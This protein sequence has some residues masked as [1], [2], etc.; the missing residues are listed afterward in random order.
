M[1]MLRREPIPVPLPSPVTTATAT[2]LAASMVT[3]GPIRWLLAA[4]AGFV[5]GQAI[6]RNASQHVRNEPMLRDK[7]AD[8]ASQDSFP[9][10]DAPSFTS[11]L[12]RFPQ[13]AVKK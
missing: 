8:T 4:A 9:A 13:A 1:N 10:S 6:R 2:L 5:A 11:G 7:L 12:R 3:R